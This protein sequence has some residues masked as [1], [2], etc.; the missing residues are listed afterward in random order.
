VTKHDN[1]SFRR[2]MAGWVRPALYE[3]SPKARWGDRM[4]EAAAVLK[5]FSMS[6]DATGG[7]TAGIDLD[8]WAGLADHGDLRHDLTDLLIAVGEAAQDRGRGLLLLFDEIQFFNVTQLE[9]VIA[10]LHK[11]VQR[12]LPVTMVG[13]G[14]PQIA[15]L[16]GDAKSCRAAL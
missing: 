5:S 7:L 4:A 6:V 12:A 8:A 10:A 2:N 14:L 13:A 1:T 9:S 11:T 16:A 3:L 15:E